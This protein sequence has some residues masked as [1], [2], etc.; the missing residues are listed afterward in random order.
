MKAWPSINH[1]ILSDQ[2]AVVAKALVRLLRSHYEVQAIVLNSIAA[3]TIQET[4]H[5]IVADSVSDTG[6]DP[7]SIRSMDPYLYSESRSGSRRAKTTLK[8][9]KI[10]CFKCSMFF[11]SSSVNFRNFWSSN[12]GSGLNPDPDKYSA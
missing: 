1:S 9:R 4:T 12:P 3:M 8:N 11:F 5:N 2:V 7:A 10:L 6:L